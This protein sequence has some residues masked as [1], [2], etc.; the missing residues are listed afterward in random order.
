MCSM[1]ITDIKVTP[2]WIPYKEP[3]RISIQLEKGAPSA[4][5]QV[6]TDEGITGV[7]ETSHAAHLDHVIAMLKRLKELAVGESPFNIEKISK[8]YLGSGGGAIWWLEAAVKALAG[9]EIA[10]WDII[11]KSLGVPVYKLLGG[12]YREKVPITAFLGIKPSKDVAKDATAAVQQGYKTLKLKVGRDRREDIEIVKA[13]RDVVGDDIELRVDPNQA[14]SPSTAVRQIRKLCRYDPEYVE[15]P[16]PRWDVEGLKRVRDAVD[17]P[18]AVCEG[19]FSIHRAMDLV[20][21]NVADIISTDPTRM[22]GILECKKLC[23][24]AEAADVPVVMHVSWGAITTSA[25]LQIC[26]S[27][28]NVMYANDLLPSNGVGRANADEVTAKVFRHENGYLTPFEAAGLGLEVDEEKLLKY[29]ELYKRRKVE[30][31][32]FFA[33]PP[34]F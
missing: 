14:W 18:I 29:G 24:L 22:G 13:V 34:M 21:R 16:V 1:K 23:G 3:C 32:E 19:A 2:V 6:Y 12:R 31:P 28:P 4:V 9:V 11:G 27:T 26:V 7:G 33:Y 5:V 20:R 15:Q 10:C 17:V 8:S 25:W 30:K